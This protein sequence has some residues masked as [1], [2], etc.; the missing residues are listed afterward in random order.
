M[1]VVIRGGHVCNPATGTDGI[2]DLRIEDGKVAQLAEDLTA[3]DGDEVVDAKG[4]Y[5]FPGFIDLHVHFR[6]PGQTQKEDIASGSCAAA[7]GGFTTVAAMP[8][9]TPPV[10]GP[11][12][13]RYVKQKADEAGL[14]HVLAVGSVTRGMDGKELSDIEG[15]A[16]EGIRAISEDGKSVMDSG[17]YRRAMKKAKEAG[18]TVLAH[19]EDRSLVEGGVIHQGSRAEQ[20]GVRGISSATENVIVARDVLLAKETGAKLHL[21]HCSTKES[22]EILRQAKAH[23]IRVTGEV[24]PHH[25]TLTDEDIPGDD[26]NYK[27]NPPLRT[28]EDV[29]AL[30]QGLK[31][32]IIDAVATDHAPHTA[33]EKAAGLESAP[34]GIVGLETAAA[35]TYTELVLGGVLTPIDMAR[36]M[37]ANPAAILGIDKGD[38]SPGNAADL[39]VFDP[40]PTYEIR[41]AEFCGKGKNMP[42]EG[43]AVTGRV[44]LTIMDGRIVFREEKEA[45]DR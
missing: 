18:L 5:V 37:S 43:R 35:L 27:M 8:N 30:R 45:Y 44:K 7:H 15:M 22:V 36:V 39:V 28:K 31:F 17:L 29:E 26:A 33:E 19:C 32:G 38:I 16:A 2:M 1:G 4:C 6:D 10:D 11:D 25:F 34:F 9:T 12:V 21:C 14:T 40:R 41:A 13:V 24:C 42:Y 20:L 3:E 23:G